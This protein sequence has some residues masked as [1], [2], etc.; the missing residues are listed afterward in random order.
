MG[1]TVKHKSMCLFFIIIFATIIITTPTFGELISTDLG[2]MSYKQEITIPIDT[3]QDQ[4][5]LQPI[6]IRIIFDNTC[7]AK[8]ETIHSVRVGYDD[9]SNINEL[10]SQIYDLK[11]IDE[12]HISEC[13]SVFLIPEN[14]NGKE[15]YYIYYDDSETS[16]PDY[17]KHLRYED[18]HYFFE[19]ISGQVIDFDYYKI[20]EDDYSIYGIL[21]KGEILG[22]GVSNSVA[23]VKINEKEFETTTMDQLAPIYMSYSIN[24]P[25][26]WAGSAWAKQVSKSVL[27]DGNLMMRF[28]I[29]GISPEGNVKTDNIYT[30]YYC[31]SDVKNIDINVYHE[32]LEDITIEGDKQRDPTYAALSTFKARSATIEKMNVGDI[33]PSLHYY[34]EDETIKQFSVPSD[35]NTEKAEWILF[36]TDDADLGSKSWMCMDD[37]A[38]GKSH[39]LIFNS[40]NGFQEGEND[41]I[42][43]KL[44]TK[45]HVKLPG[46]EADTGDLFAT[47][48]SFENGNHNLK[49][50]KG[51]KISFDLE[52]V[53][54]Q[55][56]GF[57]AVDKESEIFQKLFKERPVYRDNVSEVKEEDVDKYNLTAFVHLAPS[58]PMGPMLSAVTGKNISYIYA[59]LYKDNS[60][61]SSGSAGR[62]PLNEL[63]LEFDNTTLIEKVKIILGLFDWKNTSL[64]KKIKFP[65]LESGLYLVKIFK[66]NPIFREDRQYIGYSIVDLDKDDST[67]IYCRPEGKFKTLILDQNDEGIEKV[68]FLLVD[69][70]VVISEVSSDMDGSAILKAPCYPLFPYVLKVIYSGFLVNEQQVKFRLR[71]N[72]ISLNQDFDIFLYSLELNIKDSLGL[73]P[74]V[75]VNPILTSNEMI[76][77]ISISAEKISNGKYKF[78]DLFPSDYVLK[79]GYKSFVLEELVNLNGDKK[80]DLLFSAEFNVKL[81][82]FN[83][84]GLNLD[85]GNVYLFR[86]GEKLKTNIGG[87]GQASIVVPPGEYEFRILANDEEI[88]RQNIDIKGDKELSIVTSNGSLLH[89][90]V[91]FVG[92]IILIFGLFFIFW[93]RD[94]YRGLNVFAIGLIIIALIS[95][96]WYLSGDSGGIKTSTSTLLVPAKIVTTTSS[97]SIFGGEISI[98]P[99]E[100]TMI[101]SLLSV[102]LIFT[103]LIVFFS[104]LLRDRFL[105]IHKILSIMGVIMLLITIILF[106][107]SMS[108]VTDVG[109]GCFSGEGSLDVSIP[110]LQDTSVVP[111]MWGTGLGF[112]LGILAFIS[113]IMLSM[114]KLIKKIFYRIRK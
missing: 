90:I 40:N 85:D 21:Q 47:R 43:L 78:D 44:S 30:Y 9:G 57:E 89:S 100:L 65:D 39:G 108:Q 48:N 114:I 27:V 71:N 95:P 62:L 12:L 4:S 111:C 55:T 45:Q 109:V 61:S 110:G 3:S 14:A 13:S 74:A 106:F 8:N 51:T 66:E 63:N 7:W 73:V 99:A 35:P 79:M 97:G 24:G 19:P 37:P 16:S 68:R 88:A 46:L 84:Y 23:R 92:I 29:K 42:Q 10:E 112:Y 33:L 60:I 103:C 67:R 49:L 31:P 11:K 93:K 64:F 94:S 101:L 96:W 58:I 20:I 54:F 82:I 15:K 53:T 87:V 107:F 69:N 98:V 70:D 104:L 56:E 5:K 75:D 2:N 83:S 17:K 77:E 81:D 1:F 52:F 102:L 59:E 86:E 91:A 22:N 34:S 18:T 80:L 113:L 50:V 32:V 41:G 25:D 6:D 76:E 36:S 38:D 26:E 28:R 105:K 72:I